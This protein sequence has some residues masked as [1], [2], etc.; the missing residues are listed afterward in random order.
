MKSGGEYDASG[1]GAATLW[2]LQSSYGFV[3]IRGGKTLR[4]V[5]LSAALAIPLAV[6]III[7]EFIIRYPQDTNVPVPQALLLYPTLL[8][9]DGW[10]AAASR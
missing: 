3:I 8:T 7:G 6:A 4:D 9:P 2:A 1:V 5:A 10:V